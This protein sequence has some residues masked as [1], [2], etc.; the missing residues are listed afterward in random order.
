MLQK[1]SQSARERRI[2]LYKSDEEE[3]E[4]EE[5][6]E[7]EGEEVEDLFHLLVA[8]SGVLRTQKLRFSLC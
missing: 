3:E 1:C 5:G 6:E 8:R 2:A 7:E 4:E